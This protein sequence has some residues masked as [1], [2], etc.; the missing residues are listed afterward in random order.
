MH[1]TKSLKISET[2]LFLLKK[3]TKIEQQQNFLSWKCYFYLKPLW[4]KAV[5]KLLNK[6]FEQV[7]LLNI[8][9]KHKYKCKYKDL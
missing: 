4:K 7:K 5:F 3:L 8:T 6:S 2:N 1:L 9:E